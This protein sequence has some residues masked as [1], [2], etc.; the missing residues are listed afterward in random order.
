MNDV[1]GVVFNII[2]GSFVDGHGIR[3]T[4]F[5]KGC[6]LKCLWCCNP[7]GQKSE[8]ELKYTDSLCNSCMGCIDAC[9]EG[10]IKKSGDKVS[11][12]RSL[13]TNCFK[14]IDVCYT[15]ALDR[16]GQYYTV[17][18][19]YD[20]V[21]RDMRYYRSSGGGV[22]I[23]G[24]EASLQSEFALAFIRKCKEN[25]IHTAVDTCGYTVNE[26]GLKVLEEAD[27][28]LF[29]L[30][31]IDPGLHARNTGL[32]NEPILSALKRLDSL[33]IPIRVRMPLIPELTAT[34]DN[35]KATAEVLTSLRSLERVDLLN[36]HDFGKTK[37]TQLGREY[38]LNLSK[39][40]D[41][42]VAEIKGMLEQYSL[43]VH[44]GG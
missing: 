12:D 1:K 10:A 3:T 40:S 9:P 43:K 30:K 29:D 5:L 36:Y 8:P 37:Y 11:I 39:L 28:L 38:G 25:Y 31:G 18:E 17:D 21:Q 23:G 44:I 34:D 2:H 24:G 41:E 20:I 33:N 6:P 15:G 26:Q 7:E 14:C 22:T 35:I 13:C 19:L 27:L 4:V 32:S 16:F 42:R